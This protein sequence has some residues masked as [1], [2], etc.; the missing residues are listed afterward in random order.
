MSMPMNSETLQS[1]F[2]RAN[3]ER[4]EILAPNIYLSFG[5]S[6]M[7]IL[8]IRR[9]GFVDEIEIKISK[10]DFMADFKKTVMVK[11]ERTMSAANTLYHKYDERLKHDCLREGLHVSNY[12]SFLIPE[13][14]VDKCEIPEYAGLYVCKI[15][16]NGFA[17]VSEHK[18]A[19]RLHSRK[20]DIEKKYEIGRKMAYRFW[21]SKN[22][23]AI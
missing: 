6:E 23:F 17:R 20:I 2:Y 12:F 21:Q 8:G 11:G 5:T 4:Y 1:A 9:S 7:D 10:S 14:L 22:L 15:D 16:S 18:K 3:H 19:K 13:E